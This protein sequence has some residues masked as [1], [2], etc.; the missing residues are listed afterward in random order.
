MIAT[1]TPTCIIFKN[2]FTHLFAGETFTCKNAAETSNRIIATETVTCLIATK[3]STNIIVVESTTGT[4]AI[5]PKNLYNFNRHWH[6]HNCYRKCHVSCIV[7]KKTATCRI[8]YKN[9]HLQKWCQSE[10][11]LIITQKISE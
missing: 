4:T 8:D 9:F 6:L 1:E 11:L 5:E 3:R 7:S 10:I 2:I